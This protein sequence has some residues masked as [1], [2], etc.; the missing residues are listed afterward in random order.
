MASCSWCKSGRGCKSWSRFWRLCERGSVGLLLAV[1]LCFAALELQAA[2]VSASENAQEYSQEY[3]QEYAQEYSQ[4]YKKFPGVAGNITLVG[5]DT[6]SNLVALWSQQFKQVYPHVDIQM[7]AVGSATAPIALTEGVASVG[8]M[9]R[10][11]KASEIEYFRRQHGYAPT[12]IKVALDAITLFVSLDN[13][14]AGLHLQDIDS[15]FSATRFCGGS[16]SIN[17]WQ[18]LGVHREQ[19]T[20][21]IKLFGR[22]SASGTYGLFKQRVLCRGDFK[23]RVNELPSSASIIQSV[24]LSRASL[25]YAAFGS[26]YTGVKILSVSRDGTHYVPPSNESI[27]NGAYPLSRPLYMIVNKTQGE[28]LPD[29]IRE[30]LLFI[31]S[32]QGQRLVREAGYV[33]VLQQDTN[34]QKRLLSN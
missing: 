26:T 28:P 23:T 4:E 34:R 6:M 10:E 9:S 1:S 25:G 30:F 20:L 8:T 17:S 13:P 5:S 12:T 16:A 7:Q 15:I 31:L 27:A 21:P 32:Q 2:S 24:A 11:L 3:N 33:S 14:V 22:N 19:A 29:I 18:Q